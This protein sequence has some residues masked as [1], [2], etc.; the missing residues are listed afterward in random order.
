MDVFAGLSRVGAGRR[1][2]SNPFIAGL[3]GAAEDG[4]TVAED[5]VELHRED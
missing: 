1:V 3:V 4:I 5:T 2:L